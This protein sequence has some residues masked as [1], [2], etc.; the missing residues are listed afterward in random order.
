MGFILDLGGMNFGLWMWER[1]FRDCGRRSFHNNLHLGLSGMTFGLRAW[2][3]MLS[4]FMRRIFFRGFI[5]GIRGMIYWLCERARTFLDDSR[6]GFWFRGFI[7]V[8]ISVVHRKGCHC[9]S[10]MY[11][12]NGAL[13]AG[14]E[15]WNLCLTLSF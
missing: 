7:L 2:G 15:D 14:S 6:R 3:R 13:L 11:D 5:G 9:L 8:G 4:C 10:G 1:L 12:T